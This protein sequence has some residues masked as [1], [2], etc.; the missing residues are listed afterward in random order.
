MAWMWMS[1]V[2]IRSEL[3]TKES[4]KYE[5]DAE[6]LVD[7]LFN[8]GVVMSKTRYLIILDALTSVAESVRREDAAI[9]TE[10]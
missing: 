5:K 1:Q 8:D 4:G 10:V 3:M 7:K 6:K 2:Y 9:A